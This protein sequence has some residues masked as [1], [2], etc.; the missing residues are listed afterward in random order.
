MN[1]VGA[2]RQR[3]APLL[4][5]LG[6]Y[7][8]LSRLGVGG[9][10]ELFVARTTGQHGFEK[11]VALKR[12]LASHA[13][14]EQ[15]IQMLLAEARLAASLNHPNIVQV[16]DVG[17]VDGTYFFTMEYVF[18]QDLRKIVRACQSRG[19]WPTPEL[20]LQI[21][22]GTATGLHYAHEKEDGEGDPLG[23]VHR[24]VSPSNILVSHDGGVKLVDFGIARVSTMQSQ[25]AQGV[26][27]GKVPY[28]SPEQCRG[29]QLDRRSDI[30]SLGIILWELSTRRRLFAGDNDVAVAGKIC[31][32]DVP[33]PSSIVPD[34]P[35]RLEAIVLKAL[36]RDRN[37]R[38]ATA[39]ELQLEL[40]EYARDARM[41]LSSARLS[42][43]MSDLFA[44]EIKATKTD[45]RQQIATRPDMVALSGDD[46]DAL[47]SNPSKR[48]LPAQPLRTTNDATSANGAD[49]PRRTPPER[50]HTDV[51][52]PASRRPVWLALAGGGAL[53][54]LV[55][56]LTLGRDQAETA[57]QVTP[58]SAQAAPEPAVTPT[59]PPPLPV[60]TPVTPPPPVTATPPVVVPD[61]ELPARPTKKRII[62]APDKTKKPS[63]WD[64]DSP[65]PPP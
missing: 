62:K 28:M 20:A 30:F 22:I 57:P 16:Y 10:A 36:A 52:M 23:L 58:D 3:D 59:T 1:P 25:T 49:A 45:F 31:N 65:L 53:L 29:E 2:T 24:D 44:D 12:I 5:R 39:Q 61:P 37:D 32:N 51:E 50:H 54:L 13:D 7:E 9:M 42:G 38:Y 56:A 34:Y 46:P 47:G 55:L 17:E 43:F 63:T 18:G 15:F 11:R 35:P 8:L 21:I 64:P 40:E 60:V 33:R 26:L 48:S 14:D 19:T 27:K 4:V 6:K 41:L